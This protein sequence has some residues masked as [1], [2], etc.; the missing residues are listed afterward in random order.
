MSGFSINN[1][2]EKQQKIDSLDV[3]KVL[4]IAIEDIIPNEKNFYGTDDIDALKESI[5]ASG[6]QQNLVVGTKKD[7]KYKL[8]SGHRRFKSITELVKEGKLKLT[9]VPCKIVDVTEGEELLTLVKTNSTARVLSVEEKIEQIKALENAVKLLNADPS[10]RIKGR[11]REYIAKEMGISE[12]EISRYKTIDKKLSDDLKVELGNGNL[13]FDAAL[14]STQLDKN[15]QL[16]VKEKIEVLS[17]ENRKITKNDV[18]AIIDNSKSENDLDVKD[19]AI[20]KA[21]VVDE[22]EKNINKTVEVI[23]R[24]VEKDVD[25]NKKNNDFEDEESDGE[26]VINL[27]TKSDLDEAEYINGV[28]DEFKRDL[29]LYKKIYKEE[30]EQNKFDEAIADAIRMRETVI[31]AL[32]FYRDR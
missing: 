21:H 28:V 9:A 30:A 16:E 5:L 29:Y 12:G 4:D 13:S 19:N 8:I 15:G 2:T 3:F 32:E 17:T 24:A 25:I 23:N 18:Q 10:T 26:K 14:K 7:G 11:T 20:E 31:Q 27:V 6:L 1:Y 22:I